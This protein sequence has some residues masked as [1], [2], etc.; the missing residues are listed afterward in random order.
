MENATLVMAFGLLILS[1]AS[2]MLGLGVAFAAVPFLGFFMTDLVHQV[3]PLTRSLPSYLQ[4]AV[5]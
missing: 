3:Q 4:P 2:G 5:A 1:V